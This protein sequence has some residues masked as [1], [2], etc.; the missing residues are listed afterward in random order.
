MA[1]AR[2]VD[3][4]ELLVERDRDVGVRLVVAQADVVGRA[5][6][7]DELLL[8]KEGV[9]LRVRDQ[10][11]DR[12]RLLGHGARPG[13]AREVAADPLS[14]RPRLA[15]VE[16]LAIRVAEDVDARLVRERPALLGDRG[17]LGWLEL[18]RDLYLGH[19]SRLGGRQLR[20]HRLRNPIHGSQ[21]RLRRFL[22]RQRFRVDDAMDQALGWGLKR[23]LERQIRRR[24]FE[25]RTPRSSWNPEIFEAQ[26]QIIRRY[27]TADHSP[28]SR[29]CGGLMARAPSW[30]KTREPIK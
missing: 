25:A 17:A 9:R 11:F 22:A 30:P 15:D 10:E 27:A 5:V 26:E 6:A 28:T 18:L 14:D 3:A 24:D 20:S 4:R 1:L 7:L 8:G 16:D 29:A 13:L 12:R 19:E 2:E 21:Q 23:R